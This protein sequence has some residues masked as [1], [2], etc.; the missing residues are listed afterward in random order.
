MK[1]YLSVFVKMFLVVAMFAF[2]VMGI[3][4]CSSGGGGGTP[5]PTATHT[6]AP[7]ASHSASP[8][9]TASP[10]A[11]PTGSPT[12]GPT[13]STYTIS[14][15]ISWEGFTASSEGWDVIILSTG[16]SIA[17]GGL[18]PASVESGSFEG[19]GAH[20]VSFSFEGLPANTYY[21]LSLVDK[22]RIYDEHGFAGAPSVGNLAGT[23]STGTFVMTDPNFK[24]SPITAEGVTKNIIGI[25]F[26]LLSSMPIY[27]EIRGNIT[28]SSITQGQNGISNVVIH[29]TGQS[30]F[31]TTTTTDGSGSYDTGNTGT[32]G[33]LPAGIYQVAPTKE[34]YIFTP[35]SRICTIDSDTSYTLDFTGTHEPVIVAGTITSWDATTP[36]PN[37]TV[38]AS[39]D[40]YSSHETTNASG[41]YSFLAPYNMQVLLSVSAEGFYFNPSSESVTITQ[42]TTVNISATTESISGFVLGIGTLSTV[43]LSGE[44]NAT[45]LTGQYGQFIFTGLT[46]GTYEVSPAPVAG[47]IFSPTQETVT[48]YGNCANNISFEAFHLITI[49]GAITYEG[50]GAAV[51]GVTLNCT[52]SGGYHTTTTESTGSYTLTVPQGQSYTISPE[53]NKDVSGFSPSSRI[54]EVLSNDIIDQNFIATPQE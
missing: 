7:T 2:G 38:S 54:T 21:V 41:H 40:G 45:T 47:Y 17:T 36:I 6:A 16:E 31:T 28:D 51:L 44:S 37:A 8:T 53:I 5:V 18:N 27:G 29:G 9:P 39:T 22:N 30:S 20:S 50:N 46:N 1:K 3:I 13:S 4:G 12:A 15:T 26:S 14:G 23:Y 34:G 33:T 42:E 49:S 35:S 24:F 11:S 10:S 25:N 48:L 43:I 32:F 19:S 52:G